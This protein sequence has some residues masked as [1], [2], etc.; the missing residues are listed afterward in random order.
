MRGGVLAGTRVISVSVPRTALKRIA[1]VVGGRCS[2]GE[3]RGETGMIIRRSALSR[4]SW[5]LEKG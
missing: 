2:L 3:R 1:V 4:D 5:H